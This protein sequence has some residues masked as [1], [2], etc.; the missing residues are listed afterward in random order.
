MDYAALKAEIETGPLAAELA[1]PWAAGNNNGVVEILNRADRPGLRT[2][3][4]SE[5][6]S[7]AANRGVSRAL[8]AAREAARR[9][10][11]VAEVVAAGDVAS[12]ALWWLGGIDRPVDLADPGASRILG[13]L[14]SYG[15]ASAADLAALQALASTLISRAAEA[16]F[17]VVTT[18][19]VRAARE[20]V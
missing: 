20:V 2:V 19:D 5:V 13:D 8:V 17:G 1:A 11:A 10:G 14:L 9:E 7:L 6:Q 4:L 16:G 15:L 12:E 18:D 3:Q